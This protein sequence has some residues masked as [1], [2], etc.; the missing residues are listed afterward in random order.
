[1]K[2][3]TQLRNKGNWLEEP[4][5]SKKSRQSGKL[6]IKDSAATKLN[7]FAQLWF[8]LWANEGRGRGK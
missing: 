7:I 1:M 5:A 3:T 6:I 8:K 2:P 4:A